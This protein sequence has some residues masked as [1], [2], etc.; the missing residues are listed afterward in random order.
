MFKKTKS[1]KELPVKK[2]KKE[3]RDRKEGKG[4]GKRKKEKEKE[5]SGNGLHDWVAS[6][7]DSEDDQQPREA[8]YGFFSNASVVDELEKDL[9]QFEGGMRQTISSELSS[10]E[11]ADRQGMRMDFSEFFTRFNLDGVLQ[12]LLHQLM[13]ETELPENPYPYFIKNLRQ[14]EIEVTWEE[15]DKEIIA[16]LRNETSLVEECAFPF[17]TV[18][19]IPGFCAHKEIGQFVDPEG[20]SIVQEWLRIL[21][22]GSGGQGMEYSQL[23]VEI[24]RSVYGDYL[25]FSQLQPYASR[26]SFFEDYLIIGKQLEPALI[27]F[28][29]RVMLDAVELERMGNIVL[30]VSVE[31]KSG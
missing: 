6:D 1:K 24:V 23:Q 13:S 3:K 25:W 31:D 19:G 27:E 5:K 29:N 11:N 20:L 2:G 30:G 28:A 15:S 14:K 18:E 26:F 7:S 12:G 10:E 21:G 4:K 16:E 22:P 8:Y 9:N 17:A